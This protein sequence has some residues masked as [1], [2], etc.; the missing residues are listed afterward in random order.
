MNK[1]KWHEDNKD[2][3]REYMREYSKKYR[4]K[5]RE[6]SR[7]AHQKWYAKNRE[8]QLAKG[9]ARY[10]EK[11]ATWLKY[12]YGITVERYFEML[13]EQG[14]KCAICRATEPG[15]RFK[16][17]RFHV[18]HCHATGVVRGLLCNACNHLLG[19]AKDRPEVLRAAASY[20]DVSQRVLTEPKK[21]S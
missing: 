6:K 18:D 13:A 1:S 15:G 12:K 11:W 8:I 20:L 14:S 19:C 9:K 16:N 4:A 10:A 5:N 21:S 7:A 3:V 2:K 17:N